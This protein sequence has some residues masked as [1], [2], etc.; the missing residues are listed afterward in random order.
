MPVVT[1]PLLGFMPDAPNTTPGALTTAV[2]LIPSTRGMKASPVDALFATTPATAV[3]FRTVRKI[4]GTYVLVMGTSSNLY[5]WTGSAWSSIGSGFTSSHWSF[6]QFGDI[7]LATNRDANIQSRT[8]GS[9]AAIANA[10]KARIVIAVQNFVVAFDTANGSA[11]NNFGDTPDRWWCCAFQNPADWAISVDN[12]C[13]SERVVGNGGAITCA[14]PFGTGWVAYKDESMYLATYSGPPS[15][16][17]LQRIPGDQGCVGIDAAVNTD[18]G[19]VFVGTD[20]IWL[21][22][23]TRPVSIAVGKVKDYLFGEYST[24]AFS[25]SYIAGTKLVYEPSTK[26]VWLRYEPVSGTSNLLAYH[27]PSGQWG[28]G[29]GIS[30]VSAAGLVND[31]NTIARAAFAESATPSSIVALTVNEGGGGTGFRTW[32]FGS[33]F[34]DTRLTR[35]KLRAHNDALT[36]SISVWTCRF[37][38]QTLYQESASALVQ[39]DGGGWDVRQVAHWHVLDFGTL[40]GVGIAPLEFDAIQ[41]EL[42]PAGSGRRA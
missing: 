17:N 41:Y 23:G 18:R 21:Y 25:R 6:A 14:L 3:G 30:S 33:D 27:L 39:P 22:D 20:D 4:D 7:T 32:R 31:S 2:E 34:E 40:E 8:T 28:V 19:H 35:V 29:R 11:S 37:S 16:F 38:G 10:P 42:E 15:V 13:V 12:Q 26:L 1:V 24:T 9:F 5:E 36:G